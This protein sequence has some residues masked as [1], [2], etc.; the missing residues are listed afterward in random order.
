MIK[1]YNFLLVFSIFANTYKITSLG[2]GYGEV[3]I[4]SLLPLFFFHSKKMR[5]HHITQAHGL[6][7]LFLLYALFVTLLNDFLFVEI[8]S[9]ETYKRLVRN[10][11]YVLLFFYF[12]RYYFR[13]AVV[14][15]YFTVFS[16]ALSIFVIVQ[17]VFFY[18]FGI[19][20]D[21]H[22]PGL[23]IDVS[24]LNEHTL[25]AASQAGYIRPSGFLSE[26]ANCAHV[27]G[28]SLILELIPYKGEVTN[29]KNVLLY[30]LGMI[31]TTSAN[32]F[33]ELFVIGI[34]W[35]LF[36]L[37]NRNS[38]FS[39]KSIIFSSVFALS[40]LVVIVPK[41]PMVLDVI[42]RL[43]TINDATNNSAG[44]RVLRGP[45]FFSEMNPISK[46]VGIGFGN[47][48]GYKQHYKIDTIHEE[49]TEYMASLPDYIIS[50]GLLGST[51]LLICIFIA[52]RKKPHKNKDIMILLLMICSSSS[53]AHSPIWTL[54]ISF[55]LWGK[56][57]DLW[58]KAKIN[59]SNC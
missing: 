25:K 33:V 26:P 1:L 24:L 44:L 29:K 31:F 8:D 21:G 15:K 56:Y 39:K 40:I 51:L 52:L 16:V 28:L 41:I 45:A 13:Y 36:K 50:S 47:F 38:S 12:S 57:S 22:I 42:D 5:G 27:L 59:T 35:F 4:I 9:F 18:S 49:D 30:V 20:L 55:A 3:I 14:K 58:V 23:S 2:I 11:Y 54:Y 43:T 7:I 10:F 32:A 48:L 34:I 19:Y 6:Y 53:I 37:R 17:F 46:I